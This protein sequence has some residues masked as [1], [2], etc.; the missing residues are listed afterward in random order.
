MSLL[1]D[2]YNLL[3]ASDIFPPDAAQ[4]TL[5]NA[6]QAL[7]QFIA[8]AFAPAERKRTTIVFDAA[9]APP[10][11]PRTLSHEGMTILFS[12]R[13]GSA[14]DVLEDL[15]EAEADPRNLIVVSSDHRIQRA[16]RR[17]KATYIDSQDWLAALRRQQSEDS[18]ADAPPSD[19][20]IENPFPPG[21]GEDLLE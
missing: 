15:I 17:R 1:I 6:R 10:G 16:A 8:A 20:P 2:G 14:D 4:P 11:L 9:A 21:Y 13:K 7:L 3:F 18:A 19:T 5:E 12:P